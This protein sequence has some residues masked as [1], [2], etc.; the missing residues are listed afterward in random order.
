MI[1]HHTADRPAGAAPAPANLL[2]TD[3]QGMENILWASAQGRALSKL[4]VFNAM[5]K[6]LNEM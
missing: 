3:P 1:N 5:F 4:Q 2:E 6:K